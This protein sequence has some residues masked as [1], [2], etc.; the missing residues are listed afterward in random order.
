[1]TN[2]PAAASAA[3][4]LPLTEPVAL[5][6]S[7]RS[8]VLRCRVPAGAGRGIGDTVV[9]KSYPMNEEGAEGYAAEAAG[10]EFTTGSDTGPDLLA[11]D[12]SERLIVMTDLGDAPSLADLLLGSS[13]GPARAGL[14]DWAVAS[15]AL[16]ARTAGRDREFAA[17]LTDY[18]TG[19]GVHP[20]TGPQAHRHW[21]LRRIWEIPALLDELAVAAPAGLADDL[22]AVATLLETAE[23]LVFS[24]GDIC[25]DNNLMTAG[26]VRF[27]DFESAEFHSVYLDA[28][29]LRMPFSTCWCVFRI[30]AGL[31]A[32]AEAVYR[33]RVAG[34]WPGLADDVSWQRGVRLA[35]AAW[36]LHAMTYLLARSM[37]HDGSLNP[38]ASRAPMARQILRY[39]WQVLLAELEQAGELPAISVL[40]RQLLTSTESWQA[41]DLPFYPAFS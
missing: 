8:A 2:L 19:L 35:M 36:T 6:G 24:P 27:I 32:E 11:A 25:P 21:L 10:L 4:G 28:A 20:P 5:V 18:Q 30:P 1:V 39:R 37:A 3:L 33:G 9:V 22:A 15:G 14:L 41:E 31:A 26:G 16:A 29:Y 40:M 12:P 23:Y 34:V 38:R 17:M 13:A 7:D